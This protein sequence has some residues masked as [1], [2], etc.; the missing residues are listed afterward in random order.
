MPGREISTHAIVVDAL[1]QGK[2]VFIPYIYPEAGSKSKIMDMLRL[3]DEQDLADLKPDGWGIPSL[4]SESVEQRENAL[5]GSGLSSR[6]TDASLDLVFM[7]ATAFDA[8]N[9]RLGHGKGF[10]DRYLS[11]VHEQF[12]QDRRKFPALGKYCVAFLWHIR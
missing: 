10:Y 1:Q 6:S 8:S 9:N 11:R 12:G 3:N 5:G 2:K 7:P 4:S